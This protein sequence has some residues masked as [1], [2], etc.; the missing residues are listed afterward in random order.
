M[1]LEFGHLRGHVRPCHDLLGQ[2]HAQD[3]FEHCA[4]DIGIMAG[5][6]DQARDRRIRCRRCGAFGQRIHLGNSHAIGGDL[7]AVERGDVTF[8]LRVVGQRERAGIIDMRARD[9][10][11]QLRMQ[12]TDAQAS[13]GS[14]AG[15]TG[16][17]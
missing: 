12:E 5:R 13:A 3:G 10:P 7:V 16:P 6:F 15:S 2:C 14:F 1:L 11:E 9:V 4:K 8:G 17:S